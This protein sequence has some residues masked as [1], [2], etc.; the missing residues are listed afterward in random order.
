VRLLEH[1]PE[2][3][4]T[5]S[6][7]QTCKQGHVDN[8]ETALMRRF[9]R[10]FQR[11]YDTGMQLKGSGNSQSALEN[12]LDWLADGVALLRADGSIVYANGTLRALA[13][14]GDGF[15][16]VG[17]DLEFAAP[18]ARRRFAA[19]FDTIRRLDGPSCDARSADFAVARTERISA[20]IASVRPL[21]CEQSRDADADAI[22]LIRDPL[23]RN[24]ATN[25][26]L[27]ELFSLTNAEAHLAQALC[28][29]MTTT[30]Y[31]VERHLSLNTVYSHLK[32]IR[33]KTGCK[34]LPELIRKF[35]ELNVPLRP[36]GPRSG[37]TQGAPDQKH[38]AEQ[39]HGVKD[40][41]MHMHRHALDKGLRDKSA[42]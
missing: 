12:A 42:R 7:Q 19:A 3:L 4:A 33:E 5:I 31:A 22:L 6:V 37:S 39:H 30:A 21:V 34:S 10:N 17:H 18:E 27:Q 36:D 11:T 15:R 26:I 40:R 24:V 1:V 25:R 35:G 38:A 2:K 9:L 29:G 16:I 20:Y 23:Y 14:R 32:R 13:Q 41:R 8:R 28:N